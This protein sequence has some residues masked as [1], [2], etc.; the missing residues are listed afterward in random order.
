M[1][2]LTKIFICFTL[3]AVT[4]AGD[5]GMTV[6]DI[7]EALIS[8]SEDCEPKPEEEHIIEVIKNV[9]DAQY[10]SKCFRH[11]LMAQFDLIAEGSQIMDKEK[12]LDMMGSMFSDRK[13]DLAE[14][15]DGCNNKNQAIA[16][17]C[18][19]A[20][21]HG[22]CMLDQMKERGFEIPDLKDE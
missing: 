3:I 4:C 5:D 6:K 16:D 11:C 13:D 15:I 8:F 19:N 18:E 20:H 14:I 9:P 17:K 7:A 2:L 1:N 12:T 21:A 22:M 10:T